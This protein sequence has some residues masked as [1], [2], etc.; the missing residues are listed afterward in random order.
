MNG[1]ADLSGLEA[2]TEAVLAQ[3]DACGRVWVV[4]D[5]GTGRRTLVTLVAERSPGS[6]LVEL[7]ELGPDASLHGL[8]QLAAGV[9]DPKTRG[10]LLRD[11]R[12]VG[13]RAA[14]VGRLLGDDGRTV[15]LRLPRSWSDAGG[16]TAL[17]L[18]GGD[19]EVFRGRAFEVIRGLLSVASLRVVLVTSHALPDDLVGWDSERSGPRRRLARVAA[20]WEA[21]DDTTRWRTYTEHAEKLRRLGRRGG[22]PEVSPI[23]LRLAVGL[24]GL[25]EGP[26]EIMGA[27][28]SADAERRLLE[29]ATRRLKQPRNARFRHA[30]ARAA[31][32]R[33]DAVREDAIRIVGLDEHDQPLLTECFGYGDDVLRISEPVR[34]AINRAR[35]LAERSA[36]ESRQQRPPSFDDS[37][38]A[39]SEMHRRL[40]GVCSPAEVEPQSALHWLERV[41]HLAHAGPAG[42]DAWESLDVEYRELLW[43]RARALSR[44]HRRYGDAAKLYERCLA[45]DGT[46]AYAWHYLAFNLEKA[47]QRPEDAEAA[48]SSAVELDTR[49]PWWNGRRVRFLIKRARFGAA[50]AA[51]AA[52]CVAIDPDG[53]RVARDP[54]LAK[55]LHL[56]VAREWM[57][58]ARPLDARDVLRSIP[59]DVVAADEALRALSAQVSDALE[60]EALGTSVYPPGFP[61]ATRWV[62][63]AELPANDEELGA[64]LS[65]HPARVVAADHD[66]VK[67]VAATT[68]ASADARRVF[69]RLISADE[70]ERAVGASAREAQGF[71]FIGVYHGGQLRIRAMLASSMDF[72]HGPPAPRAAARAYASL[73]GRE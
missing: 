45:L 48:Y 53:T 65:W 59:P 51:W 29:L 20:R 63:P 10:E 55:H 35:A 37:H 28:C 36:R 47:R 32:C 73:W 23:A 62:R 6:L 58:H 69:E 21:L 7:P 26:R 44:D 19:V 67:V 11:G 49:N 71:W 17:A 39:W 18:R 40:D 25:R 9:A 22:Q 42:E 4:G 1:V 54:W 12:T 52:A 50:R 31:L 24:V 33:F 16:G 3:L 56:H 64:I 2:E 60:V 13:D 5:A 8:V 15:V 43:D 46:D 30:L 61:M 34:S 27:L 57:D 66:A 41:H 14:A 70:W 68:E 38:V 72:E